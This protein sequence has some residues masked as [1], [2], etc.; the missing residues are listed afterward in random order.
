[1]S[2]NLSPREILDT[3]LGYLGF[4]FEIEEQERD[5]HKVL[6]IFTHEADRLIGRREQ[7]LDDLQFLLN[8]ILQASNPKAPRVVVDVDHHR[9]MRDD[10]LVAK[11]RHLAEAVKS[12]GR[13]LQTEPL[14]SYDR[15]VVHNAFKDDPDLMTWSPP[16][17]A[18]LKRITIRARKKT[19]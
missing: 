2:S 16:D 6:Q 13:P 7:T 11:V 14:N 18:K 15:Y 17:D 3:M 10:A 9:A 19:S 8:R 1:M 12:T 4:V 5:G